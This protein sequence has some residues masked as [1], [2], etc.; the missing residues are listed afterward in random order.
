MRFRAAFAL[1]SCGAF[2]AAAPAAFPAPP[3]KE[4]RPAAA[5]SSVRQKIE[6]LI[7]QKKLK[8]SSLGIAILKDPLS[9]KEPVYHLNADR[10]FIPA[11]LAKIASLSALSY[12]FP[13]W[14][15]FQS[16][17]LSSA[18]AANG[19]LA[20]DLVFKGG[21]DPGFT[22]ESLWNLVNV[23]VR[24]G[25]SEIEGHL[26]I[27]DSLYR[28][29]PPPSS[30][31]RSYSAP[32]SAASF[33]WNSVTFRIRPGKAPSAPARVFVDPENSYIKAVNKVKT[34]PSGKARIKVKRLSASRDGE[35]FQLSGR[36][37]LTETEAVQYRNIRHPAF[38][39]GQN[40]RAFLSRRGIH[41]KGGIKK[42]RCQAPCRTLAEWKSRPFSLQAGGMMR[43]SNNFAVRMLTAHIPLLKGASGGNLDEGA[44][45]ISRYLQTKAGLKNFRLTEPSGL[46]RG[47]RFSPRQLQ[48]LLTGELSRFYF[49]EILA[50]YPLAGGIG[51]LKGFIAPEAKTDEKPPE[52]TK[53]VRAKTGSISGV[54]GLAGYAE[55][56]K[57]QESQGR[58]RYVFVFLFN[59]RPKKTP[60]AKALF[61]DIL[62]LLLE[63]KA[64]APQN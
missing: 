32:L 1:L 59:G 60:L 26:L 57:S 31:D 37:P 46:S 48:T 27:D 47:S 54:L 50:A 39:L 9:A 62:S 13:P 19:R 51:T 49:P 25:I 18:P 5:P 33:N 64:G 24:A 36:I 52:K 29:L 10:L 34:A 28:D 21:G 7:K 30:S 8:K 38:W 12:Y 53:L 16:A 2:F 23:F 4:S 6:R 44:R 40:I 45:W 14:F 56:A 58:Q 43:F 3:Q 17:F 22:S 20:G 11:S 42:G 61:R 35:A 41:L 55:S 63:G 15:Q